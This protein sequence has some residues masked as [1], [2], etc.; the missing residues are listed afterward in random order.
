M[1]TEQLYDVGVGGGRCA[2]RPQDDRLISQKCRSD[3]L[4]LGECIVLAHDR[5]ERVFNQRLDSR[6]RFIDRPAQESDIE[7]V[8]DQLGYLLGGVQFGEFELTSG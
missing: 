7:A 8:F 3:P 4:V 2:S 6:R 5:S 1:L